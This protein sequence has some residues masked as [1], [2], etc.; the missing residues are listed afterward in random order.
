MKVTD[1]IKKCHYDGVMYLWTVDNKM[2]ADIDIENEE[3]PFR[4]RGWGAIQN[5]FKKDY[6]KAEEFQDE[7]ANFIAE[8]INEKIERETKQ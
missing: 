1:Y 4:V 2:L 5:L 3:E 8:A 7:V 6:A